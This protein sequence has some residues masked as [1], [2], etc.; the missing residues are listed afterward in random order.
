[1]KNIYIS[2]HAKSSWEFRE[3]SDE[4]RP[5]LEKG[6]KRTKKVIDHLIQKEVKIDLILTSHAVRA[7]ETAKIFAHG[8]S[9]PQENILVHRHIYFS[10]AEGLFNEF[11]DLDNDLK[12]VM[13]VG[14]NP[15]ITAFANYF[16]KNKIDWLPTSAVVCISLKTEKWEEIF[17]ATPKTRFKLI[18][19][20]L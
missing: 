3:L 6:K 2:R 1:M 17:T 18:P 8:L 12:S 19:G 15:S 11:F 14:H 13:I 9:V 10:D 5:L 7:H 20:E 16:L 4:E